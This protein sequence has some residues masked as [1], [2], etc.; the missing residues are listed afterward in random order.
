MDTHTTDVIVIGAGIAGATAAAQIAADRKVALIEAEEQA[1]YHTTGR[2][3]AMWI[4]NYGPADVRVLTGLSRPFFE[5]PPQGFTD[6]PLMSPRPF[7]FLAPPDQLDHLHRLMA[8]G[9]GLR[10]APIAE[11][12]ARIPALR[13]DYAVAA[14]VEDDAF[15][16]DVAALHQGFLRLLRRRDGVLALRSR[17]GRIERRGG[18]WEVEVTGGAVFRAPV[19]VNAAGAWGDEVAAQAGVAPLGLQPKRRTGIIIDPAPWDVSTWPLFNDVDHTW[20]CRPEARTRLMVTPCDETDMPPHDV[21]P[22]ELDIAIGIDRMQQALAIEVRRVERAWSGLRTFTPDRSFA[23]GWDGTAE[24]F[25]WSVGQG[26][27]GIQTS[28]AAGRLVADLVCNRDPG[29]AG[30]ILS[31]VDPRRFARIKG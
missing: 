27:Y 23:V 5:T 24:G 4:L 1:G 31:R 11:L 21:Q 16:M 17:S 30:R 20:Y 13:P 29:E 12:R 3:A 26:G 28:P 6:V 19:V 18:L 14:A 2:S 15:D 10:E 7:C 22:D 9:I 8:E 25:F